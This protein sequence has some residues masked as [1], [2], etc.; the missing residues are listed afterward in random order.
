MR[1]SLALAAVVLASAPQLTRAQVRVG[2]DSSTRLNRFGRDL[3]YGAGMG[4]LYAEVDQSRNEPPEW[5][6]GWEGYRKRAA[7]NIGEFVIQEGVTEGLAAVLQRPLDYQP[8]TCHG[9]GNRISWSLWQSVTDVMPHDQHPIAIPR[10]V[11]AYVGSFAQAT[12]R[13]A[14]SNRARVAVV[15]GTVSLLIGAGINMFQEFKR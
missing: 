9:L 3:V 2:R 5:G 10:I 6:K 1:L 4:L 12:W 8:C 14:T 15:N 7:S 13:P 11:G